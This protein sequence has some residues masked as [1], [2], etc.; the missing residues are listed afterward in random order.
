MR[1][2]FYTAVVTLLMVAGVFAFFAVQTPE[3]PAGTKVVIAIEPYDQPEA[4]HRTAL[5]SSPVAEYSTTPD[6]YAG[7][8]FGRQQDNGSQDERQPDEIGG[9]TG[10]RLPIQNET[11]VKIAEQLATEPEQE[12]EPEPQVQANAPGETAPG[13]SGSSNESFS[14]PGATISGLSNPAPPPVDA[15][16]SPLAADTAPAAPQL[17]T[18]QPPEALEQPEAASTDVADLTQNQ[19]PATPSPE[20]EQIPPQELAEER[21]P[22]EETTIAALPDPVEPG[23]PEPSA[24]PELPQGQVTSPGATDLP[25]S[26]SVDSDAPEEQAPVSSEAQDQ[27]DPELEATFNAFVASLKEQERDE[28][29]TVVTPPPLPLKRPENIPAPVRTAALDSG[30]STPRVAILLRGLGRND[31][32]SEIAVTTLPPAISFGVAPYAGSPQIWARQARERGHEIL[33]QIPLE[34][35]DY[36]ATNPGP[37]TLLASSAAAENSSKLRSVL[38]RFNGFSGVTNFFGGKLLQ[39]PEALRPIFEDVKSLGLIYISEPDSSQAVTRKVAGETGLLYGGADIVVDNFQTPDAIQK[40]LEELVNL[41][42]QNGS[43][44]GLAYA[45]RTSI[46]QLREWSQSVTSKGVT[47][48][49]VGVLAKAQNAS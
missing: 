20:V 4:A 40:G 11:F 28:T 33:I 12:L 30:F 14:L 26:T 3:Q 43:A 46:E 16:P 23:F 27:S 38:S 2:L 48:V 25:G 29:V 47:L 24:E 19:P 8:T 5:S 42:R 7:G 39:S 21:A 17:S 35:A 22:V 45:S 34:P 31:R 13:S 49:P 1:L 36:P 18:A 10:D 44:I 37:D 32:N 6:E 41:A 15:V 9:F